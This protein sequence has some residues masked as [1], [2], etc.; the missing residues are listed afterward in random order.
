MD[1]NPV[2]T[3]PEVKVD[4]G[5]VV[6]NLVGTVEGPVRNKKAGNEPGQD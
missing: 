4:N 2:P 5:C 3:L 6:A 1:D